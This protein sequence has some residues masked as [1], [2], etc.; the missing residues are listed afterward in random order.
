MGIEDIGWRVVGL[1]PEALAMLATNDFKRPP[2]VLCRGHIIDR[3][4]T[5]RRLFDRE[6]PLSLPEFFEIFVE[7]DRTVIMTNQQNRTNSAFPAYIPID[8][9]D[10]AL[11]PN[12][13]LMG[14]KHRKIEREYL[15][16]LHA[17]ME[18]GTMARVVTGNG[19]KAEQAL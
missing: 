15:R 7:S 17:S 12:G 6:V 10:A 13:S 19:P 8:N 18:S 4:T 11:F 5:V 9:P 14:W 1:T 16:E 3:V 2:R